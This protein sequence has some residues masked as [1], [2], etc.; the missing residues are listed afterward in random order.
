[1][2]SREVIMVKSKL[3]YPHPVLMINGDDY[4]KECSFSVLMKEDVQEDD[5]NV[6]F[7]FEYVLKCESL[8][9]LIDDEKAKVVIYIESP[10][11]S[12]RQMVYFPKDESVIE[13]DVKKDMVSR[14]IT[15]KPYII[16]CENI[17]NYNSDL[18]NKD[19]FENASFDIRK[20]DILAT[21]KQYDVIL[22]NID[23]FKN[24]ASVFSV[25]LD[26]KVPNGIKVNYN[27]HKINV[28]V[29]KKDYEKYRDLREQ[30]E[31]RCLLSSIIIFPALVEAIEAMKREKK[32]GEEDISEKRWF[33]AMEKQ[34]KRK[35]IV[36]NDM[37]SSVQVA[38]ELLGDIFKSSLIS[39]EGVNNMLTKG[40]EQ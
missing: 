6:S 36:L 17:Q 24:C 7:S 31:F 13:I 4:E 37:S 33:M 28:M 38:N 16:A 32:G 9:T 11:S 39:I 8:R 23:I 18:F 19:Y 10:N 3:D 21:E 30:Q 1:M 22:D 27:D 34:M 5:Y 40:E 26:E 12:Y 14:K 15:A 25:R 29:N 20:G 2:F 35:N